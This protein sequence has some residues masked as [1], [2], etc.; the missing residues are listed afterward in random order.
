MKDRET[1]KRLL[2]L[3][4]SAIGMLAMVGFYAWIWFGFYYPKILIYDIK[5]YFIGH[6]LILLIYMVILFLF[7]NLYCGLKTGHLKPL[8]VFLS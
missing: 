2:I 1:G 3:L 5:L 4:I 7:S 8:V 6:I